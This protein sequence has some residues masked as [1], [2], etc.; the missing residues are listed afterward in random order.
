ML[1]L[2][3]A[4][5]FDLGSTTLKLSRDLDVLKMYLQ[6]ENE[7]ARSSHSQYI[8]WIEKVRNLLSR[9]NV[10]N[11]RSLLAFPMGH[12]FLPSYIHFRPVVFKVFCRQTYRRTDRCCQE[13]YLLAACEQVNM[14]CDRVLESTLEHITHANQISSHFS[15]AGSQ[16]QSSQHVEMGMLTK[17]WPPTQTCNFF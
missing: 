6:T 17:C 5:T 9:S 11:F 12:V 16:H 8:A 1:P 3:A 10:T 4:V 15:T 7:V 2:F 14:K 13:Q